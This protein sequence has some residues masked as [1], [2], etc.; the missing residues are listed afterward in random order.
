[1]KGHFGYEKE[2]E[3]V[4]GVTDEFDGRNTILFS[5]ELEQG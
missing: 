3:V 5:P 4:D 2:I 1:L